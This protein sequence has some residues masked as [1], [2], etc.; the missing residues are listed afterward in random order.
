MG[1]PQPRNRLAPKPR[2][3]D[4]GT[5]AMTA[6]ARLSMKE[7]RGVQALHEECATL[8][9]A[10]TWYP[11]YASCGVCHGYIHAS[12]FCVDGICACVAA[13]TLEMMSAAQKVTQ[14]ARPAQ[15][16]KPQNEGANAALLMKILALNERGKA[17]PKSLSYHSHARRARN[18]PP[19]RRALTHMMRRHRLPKG[20]A[21]S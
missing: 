15:L 10:Q 6:S 1:R 14:L 17:T 16:L 20:M 2:R 4:E 7:L 5:D 11:L 19:S 8:E 21:R 9:D 12:T 18:P 3:T 13:F